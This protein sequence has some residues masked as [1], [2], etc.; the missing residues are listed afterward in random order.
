VNQLLIECDEELKNLPAAV[1]NDRHTEMLGRI[2]RFCSALHDAV[3][4]RG[5][6]KRLVQADRSFYDVFQ[7]D[8]HFTTPKF[9][10]SEFDTEWGEQI[11]QSP[12]PQSP[13]PH[14]T[15]EFTNLHDVRD[16]IKRLLHLN[17][18]TEAHP[19]LRM[20]MA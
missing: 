8:I 1:T 11:P 4:G 19:D 20:H 3:Y 10:P 18:L 17:H 12:A 9:V 5:Q 16:V 15:T 2:V 7:K 13:T 14:A 6:E